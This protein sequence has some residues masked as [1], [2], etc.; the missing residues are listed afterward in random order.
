M[1]LFSQTGSRFIQKQLGEDLENFVDKEF[2]KVRDLGL[3]G[4]L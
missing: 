3:L 1:L 2:M 4:F